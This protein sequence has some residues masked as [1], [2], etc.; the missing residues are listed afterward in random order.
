MLIWSTNTIIQSRNMDI[1]TKQYLNSSNS[2]LHKV[3]SPQYNAAKHQVI[4]LKPAAGGM[5]PHNAIHCNATQFQLSIPQAH[6]YTKAEIMWPSEWEPALVRHTKRWSQQCNTQP[7]CVPSV[8]WSQPQSPQW[9][10]SRSPSTAQSARKQCHPVSPAGG[11]VQT[12]TSNM[13][14]R[15]SLLVRE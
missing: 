3:Q 4:N 14:S 11:C 7:F 13:A 5:R 2:V 1:A 10:L 12:I 9:A 6:P 15:L 8:K